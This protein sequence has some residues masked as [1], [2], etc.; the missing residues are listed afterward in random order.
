MHKVAAF[1]TR[2]SDSALELLVIDHPHAGIQLPAGTVEPDETPDAAVWREIREETGL[3]AVR[4]VARL[5]GFEQLSGNQRVMT[6]TTVVKTGPEAEAV[7]LGSTFNRGWVVREM[8]RQG[9][10]I[11]VCYEEREFQNNVPG[12]VILSL[13]GGAGCSGYRSLEASPLPFSAETAVARP[14]ACRSRRSRTPTL[15]AFLAAISFCRTG[16]APTGMA[17]TG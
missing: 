16:S 8:G 3:T 15:A 6:K 14:V 7:S 11:Q 4:L 5:G 2:G 13:A 12:K 17:G 1:I 10:L 9:G